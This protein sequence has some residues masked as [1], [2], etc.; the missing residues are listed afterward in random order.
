MIQLTRRENKRVQT[1][2]FRVCAAHDLAPILGKALEIDVKRLA[3]MGRS[4]AW[5][6]A[7]DWS[8]GRRGG[9]GWGGGAEEEKGRW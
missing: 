3:K 9:M 5:W 1:G 2:D 6:I 8:W 4:C 7:K